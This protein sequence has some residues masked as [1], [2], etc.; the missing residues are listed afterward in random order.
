MLST[1]PAGQTDSFTAYVKAA[2]LISRIKTFNIRVAKRI[3]PPEGGNFE[4]PVGM[5]ITGLPE[6]R[7]M[8]RL[9]EGFAT[10]LKRDL[11]EAVTQEILNSHLYVA[12]IAPH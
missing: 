5:G 3:L 6:F 11:P 10:T 7:E 1:H 2:Y 12:R 9:I 8:E 4:S